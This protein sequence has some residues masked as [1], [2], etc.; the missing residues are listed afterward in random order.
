MVGTPFILIVR[1]LIVAMNTPWL[2]IP[3][4]IISKPVY[5]VSTFSL[6]LAICV[7]AFPLQ[8]F[9]QTNPCRLCVVWQ[10]LYKVLCGSGGLVLRLQTYIQSGQWSLT[11]IGKPVNEMLMGSVGPSVFGGWSMLWNKVMIFWPLLLQVSPFFF[12]ISLFW[13]PWLYQ[14]EIPNHYSTPV[15]Q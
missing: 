6:S 7:Q 1:S 8:Y 2:C 3:P 9:F 15:T 10:Q 12:W 5:F 4:N 11:D 14:S 13:V